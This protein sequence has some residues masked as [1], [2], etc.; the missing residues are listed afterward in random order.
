MPKLSQEQLR[1]KAHKLATFV[2]KKRRAEK[3]EL[4]ET[5]PET[6]SHDPCE[7]ERLAVAAQELV[8]E[9]ANET[10]EIES[11]T[12]MI[13]EMYLDECEMENGE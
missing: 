1:A 9:A 3:P 11:T 4:K 13:L 7:A 12:L 10:S 2:V 5:E 8:V 6:E